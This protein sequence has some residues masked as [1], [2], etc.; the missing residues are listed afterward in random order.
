MAQALFPSW[1][2]IA[3]VATGAWI[4]SRPS[5]P[6]PEPAS[7]SIARVAGVRGAERVETNREATP[8][9]STPP[10]I[11]PDFRANAIEA[12]ASTIPSYENGEVAE[13]SATAPPAAFPIS[14][15]DGAQEAEPMQ[16][17]SQS[18]PIKEE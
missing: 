11:A 16:A 1:L 18:Q 14:Y 6:V 10:R 13:V 3:L 5:A 15:E 4:V 8:P 2:L 17:R 7:P 12:P 9:H